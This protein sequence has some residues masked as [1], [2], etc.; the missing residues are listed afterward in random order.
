[1]STVVASDATHALAVGTT[2]AGAG[3]IWGCSASCSAANATWTDVTPA[4]LTSTG[5]TGV[6]FGTSS[7]AWAVGNG[8]AVL[9]CPK[10]ASC[11]TA[12]GAW[13]N[14]STDP[15]NQT[16]GT[17]PTTANLL[18]TTG[19]TNNDGSGWAVGSGGTIISSQNIAP[20]QGGIWG[21]QYP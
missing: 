3:K 17:P 8:G 4:G 7:D 20:F 15:S 18:A 10:T 13:T 12:T 1:L 19:V 14:V 9:F 5:L 6:T 11:L 2:S 21:L 16:N